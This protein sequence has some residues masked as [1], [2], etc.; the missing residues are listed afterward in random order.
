M[1][2]ISSLGLAA[3]KDSVSQGERVQVVGQ[4]PTAGLLL[5]T[6]PA[7]EAEVLSGA[8]KI[9]QHG[10]VKR[11]GSY[12]SVWQSVFISLSLSLTHLLTIWPLLRIKCESYIFVDKD[13]VLWSFFLH[14]YSFLMSTQQHCTKQRR[15]GHI[16]PIWKPIQDKQDLQ[17]TAGEAKMNS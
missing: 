12:R 8:L 4:Q 13:K 15:Y 6:S 9:I 14:V 11:K 17:N 2:D 10:M 16:P 5:S 1:W 7:W 3:R